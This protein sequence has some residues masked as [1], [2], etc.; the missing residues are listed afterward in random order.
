MHSNQD[1]T[2]RD[3]AVLTI[4]LPPIEQDNTYAMHQKHQCMVQLLQSSLL[5]VIPTKTP[6]FWNCSGNLRKLIRIAMNVSQQA[7]RLHRNHRNMVPSLIGA[8]IFKWV[9]KKELRLSQM[10]STLLLEAWKEVISS[11]M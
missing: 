1:A 3:E 2:I 8:A 4:Q 7:G 6:E 9:F 5:G 11:G 10:E